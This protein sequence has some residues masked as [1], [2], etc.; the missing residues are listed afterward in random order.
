M[1][2]YFVELKH[3][4]AHSACIS[5]AVELGMKFIADFF[6]FM[7]SS[8]VGTKAIFTFLDARSAVEFVALLALNRT[9]YCRHANTARKVV[10]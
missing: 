8:T 10:I 2:I 9:L 7:L 3:N 5:E 1:F 6:L 4:F